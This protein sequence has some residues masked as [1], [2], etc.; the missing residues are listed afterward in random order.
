ME[1]IISLST[2]AYEG[3]PLETALEEISQLGGEYVELG[4]VA[5]VSE[6]FTEDDFSSAHGRKLKEKLTDFGLKTLALA[7]HMD[8]GGQ[9]AVTAF[10]RR[11]EFAKAVGA[12]IVHTKASD[13]SNK[14]RFLRNIEALTELAESL[15]LIIALENPGHGFGDNNLIYSGASGASL[16]KEIGSDFVRLNYDFGNAFSYS[17]GAIRPEEDFEPAL[18]YAVHYH[19]KDLASSDAGLVFTEI[20]KGVIDYQ[21]ILHF[22]SRQ[23]PL[24]LFAIELPLMLIRDAGFNPKRRE[25]PLRLPEIG[26]ILKNSLAYVEKV[27]HGNG[28]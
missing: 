26:R 20:G 5:G 3:Y 10:S 4:F 14:T 17:K 13:R 19:L 21:K 2:V 24:P 16:V 23:T 6:G 12:K 18:P 8:L 9:D 25:T 28:A 15:D 11:M 27:L 22:M 1:T 7:A